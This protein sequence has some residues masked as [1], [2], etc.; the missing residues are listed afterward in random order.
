MRGVATAVAALAGVL[1]PTAVAGQVPGPLPP[2]QAEL[3]ALVARAVPAQ[4]G[5]RPVELVFR[6][7]GKLV[8]GSPASIAVGLPSAVRVPLT[9]RPSD[10]L[11]DGTPAWSATL[12]GRVVSI[13]ARP[14]ARLCGALGPGAITVAFTE[15]ARLGNPDAS[16]N[17]RVW[18]RAGRLSAATALVIH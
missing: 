9:L 11:V 7:R 4:A 15:G 12:S 3:P 14:T 5:A 13:R 17:Y 10:V 18:M 16:G 2:I 6:L 1:V 8:C